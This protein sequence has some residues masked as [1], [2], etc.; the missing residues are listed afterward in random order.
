M[1][2]TSHLLHATLITWG[3][4]LI[5]LGRASG[6]Q[7]L[8]EDGFASAVGATPDAA[9]FEWAGEVA[10]SGSGIL[11]LHTNASNNTWLQSKAGAATGAGQTLVLRMRAQ[12]YAEPAVY[13]DK[14]PRG[15]RVGSDANNVVEFY[16]IYGASIGLRVRKNGIE[17]LGTNNLTSS[18]WE[19]HDYEISVTPA[20]VTFKVDGV[21]AG[22]FTSNIPTGA[23]NFYAHTYDGG[24]GNVPIFLDSMSLTLTSPSPH[25]EVEQA[26]G[27]PVAS[28][29]SRDYGTCIVGA[30]STLIFTVRNTGLGALT[31]IGVTFGGPAAPDFS[32]VEAL[33][34]ELPAGESATFEVRF[35]PATGGT[36]SALMQLASN[37]PD[38]GVFEVALGGRAFSTADDSDTDGMNDAAEYQLA[39]LGFDWELSQPELVAT[40][41]ANTSQNG[42]MTR[43]QVQAPHAAYPL[44]AKDPVSGLF[45]LTLALRMSTDLEHFDPFPMTTPQ[46]TLNARGELEFLFSPA[47]HAAFFR[48]ETD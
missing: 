27:T 14:Q 9:K 25:L 46:T 13:G 2:L 41:F 16:T 40:Y 21:V 8:V 26:V 24:A 19:M 32:L 47:D 31:G 30:P 34:P 12:A 43:A 39:A 7:V 1:K 6:Q 42:L 10:Y 23:L 28:G 33:A 36:K 45:K 5:G 29:D 37:D 11:Y 48:L 4:M 15:L 18:A 35:A 38:H 17:S 44:L 22:T 3:I 20:A